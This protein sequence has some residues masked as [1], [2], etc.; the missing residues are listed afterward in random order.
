MVAVDFR[1][2]F[3]GT[4]AVSMTS[5]LPPMIYTRRVLGE[6]PRS[7]LLKPAE[8]GAEAMPDLVSILKGR[9]IFHRELC[10]LFEVACFFGL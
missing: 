3:R 8:S 5:W 9:D 2:D 10:L 1:D 4:D 6:L 7:T